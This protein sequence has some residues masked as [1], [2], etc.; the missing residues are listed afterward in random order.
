MF[1]FAVNLDFFTYSL[2]DT[3]S[4]PINKLLRFYFSDVNLKKNTH[5]R[6]GQKE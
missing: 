6:A 3:K 5:V 4:K 1:K 2:R